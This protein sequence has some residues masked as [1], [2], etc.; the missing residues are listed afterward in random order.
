MDQQE[1]I[2]PYL[3][4][5]LDPAWRWGEEVQEALAAVPAGLWPAFEAAATRELEDRIDRFERENRA[6]LTPGRPFSP[7]ISTRETAR[8]Y[9]TLLAKQVYLVIEQRRRAVRQ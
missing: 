4:R 3:N 6:T 9:N 5:F 2:R 1:L 7:R 8:A